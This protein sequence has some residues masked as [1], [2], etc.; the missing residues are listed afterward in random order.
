MTFGVQMIGL[1]DVNQVTSCII[2]P[3]VKQPQSVLHSFDSIPLVKELLRV[4]H[5]LRHVSVVPN[6]L[7]DLPLGLRH[8]LPR[9][10]HLL[11]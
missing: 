1:F 6:I 9:E 11:R 4:S 5:R 8:T 3:L 10:A 2:D 7:L